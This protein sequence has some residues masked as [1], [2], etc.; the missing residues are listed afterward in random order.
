MIDPKNPDGLLTTTRG[1]RK[2]IDFESA[3]P[4]GPE[5]GHH[6]SST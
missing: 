3:V 1:V 4:S 2:R 5:S 6:L